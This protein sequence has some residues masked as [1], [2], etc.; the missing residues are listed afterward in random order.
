MHDLSHS[1]KTLERDYILSRAIDF[2]FRTG[3]NFRVSAGL[4]QAIW[5]FC[6]LVGRETMLPV[7]RRAQLQTTCLL[8]FRKLANFQVPRHHLDGSESQLSGAH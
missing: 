4:S 2:T 3:I 5:D 7:P 8:L 6:Q 1:P